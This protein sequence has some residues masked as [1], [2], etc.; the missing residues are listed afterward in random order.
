[1]C[2]VRRRIESIRKERVCD[3]VEL[4]GFNLSKDYL[5][6]KY[7]SFVIVQLSR[8]DMLFFMKLSLK[9]KPTVVR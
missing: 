3:F 2:K 7:W 1:M 4:S 8:Q 6:I 9:I 5:G